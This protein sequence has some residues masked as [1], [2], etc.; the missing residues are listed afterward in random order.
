V[1]TVGCKSFVSKRGVGYK[2]K[3]V[4]GTILLVR[5]VLYHDNLLKTLFMNKLSS[6]INN[7]I[8]PVKNN[9]LEETIVLSSIIVVLIIITQLRNKTKWFHPKCYITKLHHFTKFKSYLKYCC[10]NRSSSIFN[11]NTI[12]K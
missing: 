7:K 2:Q 11:N 1:S 12:K 9:C 3:T 10:S 4:V 8:I 5:K 6:D